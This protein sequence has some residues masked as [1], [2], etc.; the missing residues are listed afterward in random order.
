MIQLTYF[1]SILDND[2][3]KIMA[4]SSWDLFCDYLIELSRHPGLK[5]KD[6]NSL[7]KNCSPLI[8]PASYENDKTRANLHVKEWCGWAC[9][10]IDHYKFSEKTFDTHGFEC[11]VYSTSSSRPSEPSFR[12]VCPLTEWIDRRKIPEF[13]YA[14]SS[15]FGATADPQVKDLSRMY[16][17]P[18]SYPNAYNFIERRRGKVIDPNEI[19]KQFP[20]PKA[21][22]Y[23]DTR[24]RNEVFPSAVFVFHAPQHFQFFCTVPPWQRIK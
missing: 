22:T 18:A 9:L 15:N 19:I 7:T 23:L 5:P 4:F 24:R 6:R 1:T 21:E 13:W 8:S 17:V 11:L 16:Y 2:T 12:I 20:M 14:F 10:D 3:S